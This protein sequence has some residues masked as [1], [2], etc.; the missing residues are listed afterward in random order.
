MI[1]VVVILVLLALAVLGMHSIRGA[2]RYAE[3]LLWVNNVLYFQRMS[4]YL[5]LVDT[6]VRDRVL[7]ARIKHLLGVRPHI[8]DFFTPDEIKE[9]N[10]DN[11]D[12]FN[13][14]A[15]HLNEVILHLAKLSETPAKDVALVDY[16][17][18]SDFMLRKK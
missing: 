9:I 12:V 13:V 5:L 7:N 18:D 11:I 3:A 6:D 1:P 16:L 2:R 17:K 14:N 15:R 8:T 10:L 4:Y